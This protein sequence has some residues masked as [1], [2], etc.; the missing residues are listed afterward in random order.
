MSKHYVNKTR[1]RKFEDT[2]RL[3][4]SRKSKKDRQHNSHKKTGQKD[5]Q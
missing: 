4:R 3:I 1:S 5:K 2:K